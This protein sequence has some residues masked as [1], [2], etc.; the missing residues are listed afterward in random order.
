MLTDSGVELRFSVGLP[1]NR[2]RILGQ[3]A[4][5]LLC[6]DVPTALR[7]ATG[8][9]VEPAALQQQIQDATDAYALR[10]MLDE[11][12]LVA[13]VA[14]GSLLPRASGI[15]ARPMESAQAVA[16]RS[17]PSLL[18][19]F[20]LPSGR[21]VSGMGI[22][23]GVSLIVGG[24]YH[25]KSTL[26][27]ALTLGV[28]EH[29]AGDG[30]EWVVSDAR[31]VTIRAEDGRRVAGVDIAGF[32]DNLPGGRDTRHFN[33]DDA[34]GSTSQAAAVMEAV[35]AGA[36]VLFIDEDTAATN[37]MIRDGRMQQLIA[38][39]QEPI[40]PFIDRVRQLYD[41]HG[42]STVIV[43]GGCGDYFEVAD[44]VIAMRDY[45]PHD[46]SEQAKRIAEAPGSR[47]VETVG[48]LAAPQAR[49]VAARSVSGRGERGYL[50][51]AAR[52][53]RRLQFGEHEIDLA[54]LDQLV[55]SS[56]LKAIGRA[57]GWLSQHIDD[58]TSVA[59]LL[60]LAEQALAE[61]GLDAFDGR[62]MGDSAA[63]RRFELAAAL[64]R[65]RSLQIVH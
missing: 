49:L 55:T 6:E 36:R 52:D 1:A 59:M 26:L 63:F 19:R 58:K 51:V 4:H 16:F 8:E 62:K 27:R 42:V 13:F 3:Q 50:K 14:D 21:E 38:K 12:E 29:V 25:G 24:G 10:H 23:R 48:P 28:Y 5:A 39:S 54:A 17:P 7:R 2:R 15:D 32:I 45:L 46:V 20:T 31:S 18:Q 30:R 41:E 34:S 65:L 61:R 60:D 40:T 56:Q 64:N 44:R 35:E 33:S 11:R 37:F 43:V 47:Q 57:L 53:T 9:L 22:G